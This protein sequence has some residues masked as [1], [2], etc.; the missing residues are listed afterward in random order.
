[1][2]F[3]LLTQLNNKIQSVT[4]N[5]LWFHKV[6]PFV[7]LIYFTEKPKLYKLNNLYYDCILKTVT[8]VFVWIPNA[9]VNVGKWSVR[10]ETLW[11]MIKV[12]NERGF[13]DF[14]ATLLVYFIYFRV[15]ITRPCFSLVH[16]MNV[17]YRK[18]Q[19]PKWQTLTYCVSKI[20]HRNKKPSFSA[21][22]HSREEWNHF[23]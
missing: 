11:G 8:L 10:K 19:S 12:C 1:M 2:S 4:E 18:I 6:P 14:N 23:T 3:Y 5:R 7:S 13:K 17:Y 22:G 9:I 15:I 16:L 20:P 21:Q